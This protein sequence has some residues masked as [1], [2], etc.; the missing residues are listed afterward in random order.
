MNYLY[1]YTIFEENN[2]ATAIPFDKSIGFCVIIKKSYEIKLSFAELLPFFD[3]CYDF[4]INLKNNFGKT[5][6]DRSQIFV[7]LD[8]KLNVELKIQSKYSSENMLQL[9]LRT[10]LKLIIRLCI[11]AKDLYI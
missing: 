2:R 8:K 9:Q 3:F 6:R 10:I 7:I 1:E 4:S 11:F 5:K